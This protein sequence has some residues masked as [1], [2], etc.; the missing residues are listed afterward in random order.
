M[1]ALGWHGLPAYAARCIRSVDSN[2][3]VIASRPAV[4]ISGMDEILPGRIRWIDDTYAGGW[5]GLGLDVPSIYFQPSWATPAFNQLGAEVK[6]A[7][8]RIIVMFDNPCRWD[9]RQFLGAVRFQTQW[10]NHFYAAW[11]AGVSGERLARYWGFSPDR[12]Y[13]G[14]YGADPS[15]FALGEQQRLIE[16]PKRFIFVGQLIE[17][18][19]IRELL[20]AWTRFRSL[21]SG[22][23]LHIYGTGP[24]EPLVKGVGVVFHGFQQPQ[25]IAAAMQSV[26]FLVLPSHEEHWGLVVCEAAQAGCGL[27]LSKAVGSQADLVTSDNGFV[28]DS[29]DVCQ[30][31][32]AMSSAAAM[33]EHSL[34]KAAEVSRELGLRFTPQ[35]WASTCGRIIADI[36]SRIP[37][38]STIL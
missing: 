32:R 10:K 21:H 23:E 11:V 8:G 24:L 9:F 14:M 28:F 13:K 35:A 36:S 25:V 34:D 16:R 2:F 20:N 3:P 15:L 37:D 26:R 38:Q 4:P 1:I 18:K 12:I 22:W 6:A 27:I 17:R 7:G 31:L 19:G 30:L 5:K 33:D 29:G